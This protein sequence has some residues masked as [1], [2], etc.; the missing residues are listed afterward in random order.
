MKRLTTCILLSCL[1]LVALADHVAPLLDGWVR[2]QEA[3]FNRYCPQWLDPKSGQLSEER[4]IV[5]CVATALESILS[6]HDL[7]LVLQKD[8]P[9]WNTDYCTTTDIPAGTT[10]DTSV[11]LPNYGNGTAQSIGATEADYEASVEAV[12]RLSLM[13]GMMAHMNWGL[14]SSGADA[15]NLVEPIK[16]VLGWKTAEYIDSYCYTPQQWKEILK[17]ELRHGRPVLYTGYTMDIGGHAFVVDGFDEEDR[18]HVN[19]GYGGFYDNQYLD[20]SRLNVFVPSNSFLNSEI[21]NGFFCN[22]QALILSPNEEDLTLVADSLKRTGEEIVIEDISIDENLLAGKYSPITVTLRNT[23]DMP[24]CTPFEIFT[25]TEKD[26]SPF[27][28]GDYGALFGV[29]LEGG[30]STTI[31]VH[32]SFDKT[33]ER[34]LRISPD[35]ETILCHKNVSIGKGTKDELAFDAPTITLQA[36]ASLDK[37]KAD[38]TFSVPVTNQ[39]DERTGALVTYC[40]SEGDQPYDGDQRH[41]DYLYLHAGDKARRAVTYRDLTA[42]QQYLFYVRWPWTIRQQYLFTVPDDT[43]DIR[44]LTLRPTATDAHYYDLQGRRTQPNGGGLLIHH[45]RKVINN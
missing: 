1:S 19:W 13:C 39:K 25:N 33:G 45:G 40:L 8:L 26:D 2:H 5:G 23:T 36:A 7:P 43:S 37:D 35:D 20:I 29:T 31:T 44:H 18:F 34:I 30:E 24:L 38:V 32:C 22:Q 4:C 27:E 3:P 16:E 6:Y 28:Q 17:N 41:Y 11:I 12:A 9:A 14:G 10:I 42:G 15:G 21:G